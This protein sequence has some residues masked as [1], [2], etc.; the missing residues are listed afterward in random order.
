VRFLKQQQWVVD[1]R[2]YEDDPE[3]YQHAFRDA[4]EELPTQSLIVPLV[5][6]NEL[7]GILRMKRPAGLGELNYEDHDLLKTAGRQVAAFLAHDLA[8]ERLAETRQF[9]AYH[10]LSAFV[11]HD[12]KNVLAQQALVVSNAK[13]FRSRPEFVDDVISTVERGVQR[14][15]RVLRSLE[16][17]APVASLQRVELNKL[18]LRVVSACSDAGK[19]PCTFT[20]NPPSFWV[21]ANADQL[22]SVLTHVIQNAQDATTDGTAVTVSV[23]EEDQR[24]VVEIR[25]RG[26]GMSEEFVRR[27]LF[28]PFDSTKGSAGMG[29]GAYQAREIVR[30]LGGD[31]VVASESGRGTLVTITLP[32]ERALQDPTAAGASLA[33]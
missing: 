32:Q 7:L 11:M 22:A 1:S 5:H 19:T 31:L 18:I 9:D 8:R 23:C 30:G 2:E 25:D 4:R 29:I 15:H 20:G 26:V 16:Q 3:R 28:K 24:A 21:R 12:L 33:S 27:R 6:Q 13:K 10:K 17:G 14:M